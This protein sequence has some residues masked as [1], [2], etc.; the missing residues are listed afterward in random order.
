[1]ST[2]QAVA[3]AVKLI[4]STNKVL[5]LELGLHCGKTSLIRDLIKI[6][7]SGDIEKTSITVLVEH[8]IDLAEY[9]DLLYQYKDHPMVELVISTFKDLSENLTE[10]EKQPN[11]NPNTYLFGDG[12]LDTQTNL[13]HN[14]VALANTTTTKKTYLPKAL[15]FVKPKKDTA[16]NIA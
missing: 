11:T 6:V 9:A 12:Y 1:M 10:L 14:T 13:I 2:E 5:S 8:A 7:T 15:S 16:N 3:N 4:L